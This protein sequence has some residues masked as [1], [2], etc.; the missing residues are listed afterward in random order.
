MT[1]IAITAQGLF[2]PVGLPAE[3]GRV[4]GEIQFRG[5]VLPIAVTAS[6]REL[7]AAGPPVTYTVRIESPPAM[8]ITASGA[9]AMP[10]GQLAFVVRQPGSRPGMG[11]LSGGTPGADAAVR[12][13]AL[14]ASGEAAVVYTPP[15]AATIED[16]IVALE[17]AGDVGVEIGRVPLR[18]L[19][20]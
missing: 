14:S 7:R 15:A 9:A 19:A 10:F 18:V 16:L 8:R 13:F 6:A 4:I 1:G 11:T 17:H 12:L 3:A 20:P 2:W 5:A